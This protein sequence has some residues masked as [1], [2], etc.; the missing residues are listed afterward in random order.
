MSKRPADES[1][2]PGAF[3]EAIQGFLNELAL[4]RNL[5]ANT[6]AAYRRDLDEC[7]AFLV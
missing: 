1:R 3:A 2:A 4:E 7:A 6:R 5:S